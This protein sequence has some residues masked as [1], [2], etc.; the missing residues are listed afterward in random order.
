MF[1]K[2]A[3]LLSIPVALIA[4]YLICR[5]VMR[6]TK[7]IRQAELQK[8]PLQE[9]SLL[10]FPEAGNVQMHLEGPRMSRAFIG[11]KYQIG[12]VD[13]TGSKENERS[14]VISRSIGAVRSSS[15]ETVRDSYGEVY[16]PAPGQYEMRI[17]GLGAKQGMKGLER[18]RIVFTRPY[19]FAVLLCILGI[20]FMGFLLIGGVVLS[21][22]ILAV[23]PKLSH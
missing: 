4:G 8:V 13:P 15:F 5:L 20:V 18:C 1:S 23:L 21:G 6:L 3:L 22:L 9:V 2:S 19:T 16:V 12:A 7:V 17:S 11:L 10:T 14:L